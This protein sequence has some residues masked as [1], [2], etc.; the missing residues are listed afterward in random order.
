[1]TYSPS[2]FIGEPFASVTTAASLLLPE[3]GSTIHGVLQ[4]IPSVDVDSEMSNE[5]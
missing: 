4:W 5:P 1:M 2:T 3:L